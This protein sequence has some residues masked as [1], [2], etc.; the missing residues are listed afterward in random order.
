METWFYQRDGEQKGP[1]PANQIWK[2]YHVGIITLD[3]PVWKHGMT[4]FLPLSQSELMP[5]NRPPAAPV[6]TYAASKGTTKKI[7]LITVASLLVVLLA[8][9]GYRKFTQA[10]LLDGG[11][12]Y[13]NILGVTSDIFLFDHGKMWM[14]EGD[15]LSGPV[16]YTIKS[17]GH[18]SYILKVN[19]TDSPTE[20][21]ISFSNNDSVTIAVEGDSSTFDM[22]RI[23]AAMAKK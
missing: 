9:F 6:G 21:Y 3:T 23:D 2:L 18:N 20:V 19:K 7:L 13:K 16:S 8:V 11:W 1:L 10:S 5:G 22:T 14:Y 17:N 4:H 15:T 12:Q